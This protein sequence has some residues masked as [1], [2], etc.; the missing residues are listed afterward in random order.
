MP[1]WGWCLLGG[2]GG[3]VGLVLV[4]TVMTGTELEVTDA[5][6]MAVELEVMDAE[7][8]AVELAVVL[9]L[10]EV[11]RVTGCACDRSTFP[12]ALMVSKRFVSKPTAI[13][14]AMSRA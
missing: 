6:V 12:S 11:R 3:L 4:V 2:L 14:S 7:V 5:E 1:V 10:V 13:G 9:I 8:M